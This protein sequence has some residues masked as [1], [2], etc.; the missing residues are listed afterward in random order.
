MRHVDQEDVALAGFGETAGKAGGCRCHAGVAADARDGDELW[1]VGEAPAFEIGDETVAE[2]FVK[3]V[4][5][6]AVLAEIGDGK[7]R[8]ECAIRARCPADGG[9]NGRDKIQLR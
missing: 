5:I 8:A 2:R 7:E 4:P 6:V 9:W 1:L 3:Y